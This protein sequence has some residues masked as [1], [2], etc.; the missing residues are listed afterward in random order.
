MIGRLCIQSFS[1]SKIVFEHRYRKCVGTR[2]R[3]QCMVQKRRNR[4]LRL[5]E[6]GITTSCYGKTFW[7]QIRMPGVVSGVPFQSALPRL[8]N[9]C[10]KRSEGVELPCRL[11]GNRGLGRF[12]IHG[13]I[14]IG[15]AASFVDAK[16]W[17]V[18]RLCHGN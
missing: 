5:S 15:S 1:S 12:A 10:C 11:Q 18:K 8:A 14:L 2:R 17:C 9:Q 16:L 13:E 3:V 4:N 6:F 7:V